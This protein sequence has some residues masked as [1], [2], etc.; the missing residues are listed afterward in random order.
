MTPWWNGWGNVKE[1][2]VR[3]GDGVPIRRAVHMH[4]SHF[5]G[6]FGCLLPGCVL[7]YVDFGVW[8]RCAGMDK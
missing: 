1:A 2:V 3:T 4:G 7:F 8:W 5:L 6:T